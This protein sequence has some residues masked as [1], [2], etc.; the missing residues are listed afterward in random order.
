MKIECCIQGEHLVDNGPQAAAAEQAGFDGVW[1]LENAH[2]VFFRLLVAGQ[3]TERVELTTAIAVAF[4]RNPM[5]VAISAWDLQELSRGRFVLGLGAQVKAHIERR[6]SMPWSKPAARMR[7]YV[8]ALRAIWASWSDGTRLD[9]HGDFYTHT[10]MSPVFDPGPNPYGPPKIF[11]AGVGDRMTAVAG[12]VADGFICH[13][14]HTVD[15]L[16]DVTLPVLGRGLDASGRSRADF[17]ISIPVMVVTGRDDEEVER[18]R[19]RVAQDIGFHSSTPAYRGVLEQ[20]G[21]GELHDQARAMVK[22]G[23]WDDL[24]DLVDDDVLETFAVVGEPHVLPGLLAKRYAHIADRLSFYPPEHND[25]ELLDPLLAQLQAI[26]TG[27]A[28][29]SD[30]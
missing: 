4:A 27:A 15:Y 18:V 29:A 19:R 6:F 9:F 3:H 24:P 26:P 16:R 25:H 13:P 22:Q 7:E 17:E 12:E 14:F 28:E 1:T 20:H 11:L 10:L 23:R 2:D 30:A 8:L 21:W 5:T